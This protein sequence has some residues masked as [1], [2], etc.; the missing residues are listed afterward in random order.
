MMTN[1]EREFPSGA[2][3]IIG[4]SGGVG[5]VI[6]EKLAQAHSDIAL[7]YRENKTR[8]DEVIAAL[9]KF[10]I[11]AK[12]FPLD[13]A[14]S[15]AVQQCFANIA[16][17]F[18]SIH[19]V[20]N[21]T[22]SNIPMRFINQV[23]ENIWRQ[24]IDNDLNGFFNIAHAALPYLRQTQGAFVLISSIGLQRWPKRDVLSVAPKAGIEAL[25]KGIADRKSTRLNSSH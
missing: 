18:G 1:V 12:V 3:I 11:K 25:M 24:V 10:G 23:P 15:D 14:N 8:A 16:E 4:G 22:G 2:A 5:S 17:T 21:S 7:I 13:I 6:C 9:E 19:T 20:V